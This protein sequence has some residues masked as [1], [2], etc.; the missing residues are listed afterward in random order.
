[1]TNISPLAGAIIDR[2]AQV[3]LARP[4]LDEGA[5]ERAVREHLRVLGLRPR[6]LHW[7]SDV[8]RGL[9]TAAAA[10]RDL[11][12]IRCS[13]RLHR[14]QRKIHTVYWGYGALNSLQH[15]LNCQVERWRVPSRIPWRARLWTVASSNAWRCWIPHHPDIDY[16]DVGELSARPKAL[17]AAADTIDPAWVEA[18]VQTEIDA[19]LTVDEASRLDEVMDAADRIAQRAARSDAMATAYGL[20]ANSLVSLTTHGDLHPVALFF[21][22]AY[23]LAVV[24][25]LGP[26][27]GSFPPWTPYFEEISRPPVHVMEA[28]RAAAAAA[29]WAATY[30]AADVW[31]RTAA[32][33][34]VIQ[35]SLPLVDAHEAG[36]LVFCVL[37]H[38]VLAVPRPVIHVLDGRLHCPDGPA[39]SWP[40]G[41]RYYYWR[42]L[43]VPEHVIMRP[44][45]LSGH[46]ILN[47]RNVEVRRA[48]IERVG[49]D[50]F[51]TLLGDVETLRP[52]HADETGELYRLFE[53]D[54]MSPEPLVVVR[55]TDPSTGRRY[56]LRVPP[57]IQTAREA[58]AWSFQMDPDDWGPA[59]ET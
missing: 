5:V 10:C 56:F 31:H 6:P 13:L 17:P 14:A 54:Y 46:D 7:I 22:E 48:M 26:I 3:D 20:A 2:L 16:P 55:L 15:H 19:M 50:R 42:G 52:V 36:L 37:R 28:F 23:R 33:E 58:L 49:L 24:P 41:I 9:I 39:V 27:F 30:D 8:E 29:A 47:E 57:N 44:E 45:T 11:S 4:V 12:R 38:E 21:F 40:G 18:T 35:S 34:R 43:S 32:V 51:L 1:M 53:D 59:V 25:I